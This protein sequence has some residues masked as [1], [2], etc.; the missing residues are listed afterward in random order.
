M[1]VIEITPGG[2]IG[3]GGYVWSLFCNA[4]LV[5]ENESWMFVL[6]QTQTGQ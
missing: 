1:I 6:A 2:N 4:V 5:L 3:N